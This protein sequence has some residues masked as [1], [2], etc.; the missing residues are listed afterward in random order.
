MVV[1][2][3]SFG[4]E[5]HAECYVSAMSDLFREIHAVHEVLEAW[6]RA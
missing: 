2:G 6:V 4:G 5:I 3:I 1:I